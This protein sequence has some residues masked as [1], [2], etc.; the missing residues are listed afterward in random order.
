[1]GIEY[2]IVGAGMFGSVCAKELTDAGKK[3]LVIDKNGF[4]GGNCA[5]YM[6]NGYSVPFFGGHSGIV[7]I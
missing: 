3:V 4:V 6:Y 7:I 2:L 1:M 5:D